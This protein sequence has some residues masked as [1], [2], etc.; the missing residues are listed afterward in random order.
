MVQSLKD[1][2]LV[3]SEAMEFKCNQIVEQ[4]CKEMMEI[5][6]A[7]LKQNSTQEAGGKQPELN[8]T[9]EEEHGVDEAKEAP[10]KRSRKEKKL[11]ELTATINEIV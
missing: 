2:M 1:D 10:P 7:T 6:Q 5:F 3:Q 11:N 4:R 8:P 9:C